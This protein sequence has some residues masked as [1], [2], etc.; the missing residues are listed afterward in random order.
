MAMYTMVPFGRRSDSLFDQM[1][2]S[3]WKDAGSSFSSFPTDIR[4]EGD[5]FTL[6]AE[7]PGFHKEDIHLSVDGGVLTI[8]AQHEESNE[9]KDEK[10]GYLCRE[11]HYGSY[12]RSFS[13][14]GIREDAISASY[15]NGVLKLILPK[16]IP[17]V[18]A[19]RQIN[20]Q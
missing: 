14:S 20:I 10:G 6:S 16:D 9:Q 15:E 1:E 19:A 11:R 18:P 17:V 13:I 3:F 4:D 5:K 12:Q 2:R 8:S 7:L